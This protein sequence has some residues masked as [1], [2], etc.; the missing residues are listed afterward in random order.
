MYK[1]FPEIDILILKKKNYQCDSAGNSN[2][3]FFGENSFSRL[4]LLNWVLQRIK[5]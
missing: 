2:F 5:S 4:N 1:T 3:F